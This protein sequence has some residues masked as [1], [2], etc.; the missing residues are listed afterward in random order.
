[1]GARVQDTRCERN[2]DHIICH[3]PKIVEADA[4]EGFLAQ[5]NRD[6]QQKNSLIFMFA[7]VELPSSS[8]SSMEICLKTVFPQWWSSKAIRHIMN[9]AVKQCDTCHALGISHR[10]IVLPSSL[11]TEK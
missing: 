7:R 11:C 5:I 10:G 4:S 9:N 3:R 1:M 8:K 2:H 6:L